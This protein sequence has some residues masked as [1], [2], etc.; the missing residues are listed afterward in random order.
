MFF[1]PALKTISNPYASKCCC[2][3][4]RALLKIV[5]LDL[6]QMFGPFGWCLTK[7]KRELFTGRLYFQRCSFA[8][9]PAS[10][11][12]LRANLNPA[13]TS[14][15]RKEPLVGVITLKNFNMESAQSSRSEESC[16]P[17]AMFRLHFVI[18]VLISSGGITKICEICSCRRH[19]TPQNEG[20]IDRQMHEIAFI[21]GTCGE[22]ASPWVAQG[23]P[24][25]PKHKGRRLAPAKR[26]GQT[27]GK[28]NK[29]IVDPDCFILR[30]FGGNRP[31]SRCTIVR[32]SW[33]QGGKKKPP[34]P[35]KKP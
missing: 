31:P 10:S 14:I 18:K 3:C 7:I 16:L 25:T 21:R 34:A 23:L 30:R 4:M 13:K 27:K 19:A 2:I 24:K 29:P 35:T 11:T 22:V 32:I 15:S 17:D 20:R 8:A 9:R 33:C 26:P 28:T 12:L 1:C 6:S 5:Q